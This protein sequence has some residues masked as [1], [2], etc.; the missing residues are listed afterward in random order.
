MSKYAFNGPRF[1]EAVLVILGG[2]GFVTFWLRTRLWLPKY[3]HVLAA[4]GLIVGVLSVWASPKDAPI[5]Q[6]GL[7]ACVL[8][9]FALP[10]I[11][12]AYFILHGGQ[13]A[14]FKRSFPGSAP[15]P[16][17]K[18]PVDSLPYGSSGTTT[19]QFAPSACPHCSHPLDD[20]G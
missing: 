16:F 20:V 7:M 15:C 6:Q 3:I 4:V 13:Y 1:I 5:K 11:I 9:A 19:A 8:L 14:A 2:F 18:N 10:I 17:C 12:Y